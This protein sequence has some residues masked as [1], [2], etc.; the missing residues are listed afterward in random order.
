MVS[1]FLIVISLTINAPM[2]F[3]MIIRGTA[4]VKAKAPVTPSM[5]KVASMISR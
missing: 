2:P 4:S 1:T 5:E 3:P